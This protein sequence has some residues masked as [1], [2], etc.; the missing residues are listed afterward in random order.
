M[1]KTITR[2]PSSS[3]IGGKSQLKAK[4][5]PNGEC[6]VWAARSKPMKPLKEAPS[7]PRYCNRLAIAKWYLGRLASERATA[8][9]LG[10]SI[11]RNFDKTLS[12]FLQRDSEAPIKRASY[13]R[14]GITAHGRRIVRN[15]AY[16]IEK[17][18]GKSRTVFATA[19]IPS[20][21][22]EQ[23]CI[24]QESWHKVVELYRLGMRRA[25]QEQGLSGE[26]VTVS[27]VQPHRYQETGIP[28]L[29]LHSVFV[30][31]TGS[32][33]WAITTE[34]HDRIWRNVLSTVL[35][36]DVGE[37]PCACNLQR[38]R[39]S[40]SGYL[41][42]YM[43]KGSKTVQ[44]MVAAGFDGWLP[45]QWWSCSQSLR[46]RIDVETEDISE[47]AETLVSPRNLEASGLWLWHKEVLLEMDDGQ[48]C[49]LCI[50]GALK[51]TAIAMLKQKKQKKINLG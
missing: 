12:A 10:L 9:A 13:G 29:H 36:T 27:E 21:P 8:A 44:A 17:S 23:I 32:G 49:C 20:L 43:S 11:L 1:N 30:G 2:K 26:L 38:V 39:K 15:A 7:N 24:V 31:K 33:R 22:V 28:V 47:L 41:G 14:K 40:A 46:R 45:K 48:S 6:V 42:K 3:V 18:G 16:L 34:G 25:L 35:G 37:V 5:L 19:T 51:V 50:Y 4:L